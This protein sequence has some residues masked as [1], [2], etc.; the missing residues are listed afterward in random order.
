M[1]LEE[2]GLAIGIDKSGLHHI[3]N[4]KPITIKTLLKISA[5]LEIPIA[6]FFKDLPMLSKD[7]LKVG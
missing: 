6:E 5:Y 7:D 2:V 3:E 4:G 1:T